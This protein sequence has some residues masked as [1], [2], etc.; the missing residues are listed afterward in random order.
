MRRAL[1]P[2][3]AVVVLAIAGP[4]SANGRF[5][6]ANQ[7]VEDPSDPQRIVVRTTYGVVQTFDG[8]ASWKWLCES[9]VGYGG[10]FDPAIG[11]TGTGSILAGIFDG[12]AVGTAKGCAFATAEGVLKGE[13]VIDLVVERADPKRA[14]AM[15]S[16]GLGDAGFRVLLGE[17]T[18]GG[19]TWKQVGVQLPTDFNS[20]T[21]EIAQSRPERLYASG[22]TGSAP[23][24]GVIEKSDDRGATWERITIDL[25]GAKAPYLAAVDPANPDRVYVRVDGDSPDGVAVADRLLVSDDGAKTWREVGGTVGDMFGFALSPDGTKVAIGGPK[26]GVLVAK[27]SDFVF[28]RVSTVGARCLTW[29]AKGLY[30]CASE[31]PD[32]FTVGLSTDDG[33]TFAPLYHLADLSP[34]ECPKESATGAECPKEWPAVQSTIGQ[35]RDAGPSKSDA[36][37]GSAAAPVDDGGGCGCTVVGARAAWAPLALAASALA[38][39]AAR[40]RKR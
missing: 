15:T 1:G 14:I 11:V 40:R 5:P 3:L 16:S 12:L 23:R 30:A 20:E 37:S 35:E 26:D 31:Y 8:G 6:F 29:T 10:I 7:L 19:A 38:F 32:G 13:Y 22:I 18:D 21:I 34:L 36:G 9:S 28:E 2:A 27:T 4:A 39:A 17:T 24:V 25:K 33:K